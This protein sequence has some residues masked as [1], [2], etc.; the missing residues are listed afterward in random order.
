MEG[1]MGMFDAEEGGPEGVQW[2]A[3]QVAQRPKPRTLTGPWGDYSAPAAP[4]KGAKKKPGTL[5]PC[6]VLPW[7]KRGALR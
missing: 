5:L 6:A 4:Q 7:G 1:G 2:A 3:L